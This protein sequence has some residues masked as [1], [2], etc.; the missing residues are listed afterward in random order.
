MKSC[1]ICSKRYQKGN[2]ISHSDIKTIRR[3]YPNLRVKTIIIDGVS[4]KVRICAKC[5]KSLKR[6][7]IKSMEKKSELSEVKVS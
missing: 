5:L 2:K 1:V 3:S 4:R 6:T 7:S